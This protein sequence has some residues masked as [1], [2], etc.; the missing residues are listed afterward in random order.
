MANKNSNVDW[1]M[2]QVVEG[3]LCNREAHS[4]NTSPAKNKR[5]KEK[6]VLAGHWWL[7]IIILA[8]QRQ[9]IGRLRFKATLGFKHK[10][11]LVEWL[12]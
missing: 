12:K 10:K 9:R 1:S 7:M 11:G 5:K 2:V 4:S 8:T 3:L 6:F